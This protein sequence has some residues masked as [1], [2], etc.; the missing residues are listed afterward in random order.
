MAC[1]A[2]IK[3][4][5]T[6]GNFATVDTDAIIEGDIIVPDKK[7]D[8]A[9]ILICESQ[10]FITKCEVFEDKINVTGNVCFR[11]LYISEE[12]VI[13][14]LNPEMEFSKVVK[15]PGVGSE[16]I[17]LCDGSVNNTSFNIING[18]K[19]GLRSNVGLRLKVYEHQTLKA[20]CGFETDV[21]IEMKTKK[22]RTQHIIVSCEDIISLSDILEIPQGKPSIGEVLLVNYKIANNENRALSGKMVC[23][24]DLVI[25]TLYK[26]ENNTIQFMEHSVPFTEILEVSGLTEEMAFTCKLSVNSITVNEQPDSDGDMRNVAVNARIKVYTQAENIDENEIIS[27]AYAV[28]GKLTLKQQ[29]CSLSSIG[30][31]FSKTLELKEI[32]TLPNGSPSIVQIYDVM[33]KP[34]ITLVKVEDKKVIIEGI[35]IFDML[36]LSDSEESPLFNSKNQVE[37]REIV[38]IPQ[39]REEDKCEVSVAMDYINYN[40]SL[41]GEVEVRANLLIQVKTTESYKLRFIED[42]ELMES[43]ET[44]EIQKPSLVIY[45]VQKN[46]SLWDIAKHYGVLQNKVIEANSLD[47]DNLSG[48][49]KLII[50][51][52]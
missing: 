25:T 34:R 42:A 16:M 36:Y 27:D 11:V 50:P 43:E 19:I 5:M 9:K 49:K 2:E 20:V 21:P 29:E 46:D 6:T 52:A 33:A 26:G 38:D 17:V 51:V 10:V 40:I 47:G 3:D 35:T 24:G 44:S 14:S 48:V 15:I 12:N 13:C 18:R 39:I 41:S 4:I 7:G 8:I 37:W 22:I 28:N 31:D 45:F 30:D 1:N 23:K 32:L